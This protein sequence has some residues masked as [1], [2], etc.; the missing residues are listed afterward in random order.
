M[1]SYHIVLEQFLPV[2]VLRLY[3]D[4]TGKN[5]VNVLSKKHCTKL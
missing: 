2:V 1:S 5:F 3:D 4:V